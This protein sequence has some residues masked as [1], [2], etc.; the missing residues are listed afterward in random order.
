MGTTMG[1]H[2]ETEGHS[3]STRHVWR[4]TAGGLPGRTRNY[5]EH[6]EDK[7]SDEYHCEHECSKYEIAVHLISFVCNSVPDWYASAQM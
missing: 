1:L 4:A 6:S 5:S 3:A 7:Q 2:R